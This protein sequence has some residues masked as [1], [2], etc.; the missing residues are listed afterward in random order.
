M[1]PTDRIVGNQY[2]AVGNQTPLG[3]TVLPYDSENHQIRATD[4]PS[5]D[6]LVTEYRY[7]GNGRR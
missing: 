3:A 7:D 1:M 2:D 6:G 4:P 5:S